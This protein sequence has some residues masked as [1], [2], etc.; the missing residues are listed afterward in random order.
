MIGFQETEPA[1]QQPNDKPPFSNSFSVK[2][3][4]L[5]AFL[6]LVVVLVVGGVMVAV[7]PVKDPEKFGEGLGRFSVFIMLAA[8]GI[9][10]LFQTGR[11]RVAWASILTL[12]LG[13]AA[14]IVAVLMA[15]DSQ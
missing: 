6:A 1:M 14:L 9:S 8:F 2:K 4:L 13:L 7:L 10:W 5:Y 3:G 12:L 15:L 11:K